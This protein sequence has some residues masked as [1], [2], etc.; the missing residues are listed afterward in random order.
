MI[1]NKIVTIIFHLNLTAGE[2][3][4]KLEVEKV[5]KSLTLFFTPAV[6]FVYANTLFFCLTFP[7]PSHTFSTSCFDNLSR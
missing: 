4:K 2:K 7:T 3:S 1:R 5:F 6:C